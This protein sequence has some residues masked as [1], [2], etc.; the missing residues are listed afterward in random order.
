M[1]W[2]IGSGLFVKLDSAISAQFGDQTQTGGDLSTQLVILKL[3]G[4]PSV[5]YA[6]CI[7]S[8]LGLGAGALRASPVRATSSAWQ[9][10]A[11]LIASVVTCSA[12]GL[13]YRKKYCL[14]SFFAVG[15]TFLT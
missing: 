10:L 13:A 9:H 2:W 6:F 11:P 5:S 1:P 3:H 14:L 8:A 4:V 15:D 7:P 12:R